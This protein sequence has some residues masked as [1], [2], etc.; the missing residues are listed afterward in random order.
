MRSILAVVLFGGLL[1]AQNVIST[2]AGGGTLP[3]GDGGFATAVVLDQP[4]SIIFDSLGNYYFSDFG[5]H[6]VRKVTP[7][8]IITTVAGTGTAGFSGD[9]GPATV[10]T[11]RNPRGLALDQFGNLYVADFGNHRIRR[12]DAAGNIT[13]VAGNG[14]S[15]FAGDGLAAV[16]ASLFGPWGVAVD[17]EGSLYIADTTNNRIRKVMFGVITTVVG[18]G[19]ASSLGDGGPPI[20]AN[21]SSPRAVAVDENKVLYIAEGNRIR[22]ATEGG[23]ISTIAGSNTGSFSGDGGLAVL[24]TLQNPLGVTLAKAASSTLRILSTTASA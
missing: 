23:T 17:S 7:G 16:N 5:H 12:V 4:N 14:S 10:A 2:V 6:R 15:G 20:N 19:P 24:A 9:G 8:G 1:H 21:L 22:R 18:S 11:L 3:V 13:T